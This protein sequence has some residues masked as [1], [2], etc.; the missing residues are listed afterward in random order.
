MQN[1]SLRPDAMDLYFQG[2]AF[3][4]K[5]I[6]PALMARARDFF[7]RAL[8]LDPDHIEAAVAAAHVDLATGSS[9]MADD[10]PAHFRAAEKALNNVLLRVPNHPE[11]I[12]SLEPFKFGQTALPEV[13]PNVGGR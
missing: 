9:S 3:Q 5:G 10:G 11:L 13:S 7:V 4:N 12:C 1:E 8:A 2:S 6:T